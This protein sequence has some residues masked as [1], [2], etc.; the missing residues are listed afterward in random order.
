M[1]YSHFWETD[2]TLKELRQLANLVS[3]KPYDWVN[4]IPSRE[5]Y[6]FI[7]DEI[8]EVFLSLDL[9]VGRIIQESYHSQLRNAFAHGQYAFHGK[10]SIEL[11]N[12]KS[13]PHELQW[14]TF[15]DWEQRFLKA[16]LLFYEL[17]HAKGDLL[18]DYGQRN[19]SLTIWM[20]E[21]PNV[22][23]RIVTLLWNEHGKNY[24]FKQ[25]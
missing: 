6:E 2:S 4:E 23:Y 19:A 18:E 14:I 1:I 24:Y 9:D 17:L 8:R 16:A 5:K 11:R 12:Y 20:P 10:N 15:E 25:N 22:K 7:R 13:E 3:G 21:K